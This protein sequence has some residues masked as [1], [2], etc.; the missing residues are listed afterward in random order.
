MSVHAVLGTCTRRLTGAVWDQYSPKGISTEIGDEAL[1]LHL[2]QPLFLAMWLP[3]ICFECRILSVAEAE[4]GAIETA[5][6][7]EE[8]CIRHH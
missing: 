2:I 4:G 5:D 7:W 3:L 1:L 8:G 6:G